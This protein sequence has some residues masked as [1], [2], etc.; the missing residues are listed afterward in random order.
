MSAVVGEPDVLA[1]L[2][3]RLREQA[4]SHAA[5]RTALGR[6]LDV[7]PLSAG[8]TTLVA[9]TTNAA[10]G[11]GELAQSF[12]DLATFVRDV[13]EALTAADATLAAVNDG[14]LWAG[15]SPWTQLS[16]GNTSSHTWRYVRGTRR[17]Y[18]GEMSGPLDRAAHS[19]KFSVGKGS[20]QDGWTSTTTELS[21]ANVARSSLMGV[22][23]TRRFGSDQAHVDL[24][25]HAGL[26]MTVQA[27][28][29]VSN[30]EAHLAIGGRVELGGAVSATAMVGNAALGAGGAARV[31]AGAAIEAEATIKLGLDGMQAEVQGR[32]LAGAEAE[33]EG[34][35]SVLGVVAR[36]HAGVSVG[37]G[38]QYKAEADIGL[39]KISFAVDLGATI[40]LGFNVGVDVS[41][42]PRAVAGGV[43]DMVGGGAGA[44]KKGF[45]KV[46]GLFS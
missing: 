46:K 10:S 14:W 35:V 34:E 4:D 5:L 36:P 11:L 22:G 23:G 26:A 25:A 41:V 45:Q 27:S 38:V 17:V 44:A 19:R 28:A 21:L 43:V 13:S 24:H 29:G 15:T 9:E 12:E 39:E 6:S 40:G 3:W 7:T 16:S 30:R 42:N 2:A 32:I 31:F 1:E 33:V 37:V 18:A 8:M 20:V